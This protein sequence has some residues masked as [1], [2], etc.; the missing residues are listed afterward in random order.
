M[1][2]VDVQSSN[3]LSMGYDA[4][5]MLMEVEF[6][7]FSVYQY[8]NVSQDTYARVF[9]GEINGSI[10][11]TFFILIKSFPT[12]YPPNKVIGSEDTPALTVDDWA[13]IQATQ[14]GMP[15]IP[16]MSVPGLVDAAPAALP[17]LEVAPAAFD[18]PIIPLPVPALPS[19]QGH[20]DINAP[21]NPININ[22]PG[23]R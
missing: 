11:H 8:P 1:I 20:A 19:R 4:E 22:V 21:N 7:D 9:N 15:L 5:H 16:D 12:I 14:N 3:L 18:L 6:H 2:R 23:S 17:A 13:N 10:G